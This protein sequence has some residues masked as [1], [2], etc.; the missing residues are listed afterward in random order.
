M[1][2]LRDM[3]SDEFRK[4]AE[5]ASSWIARYL[6]DPDDHPV[7]ARREPG[8]L[9]S[10]LPE[11]PP[12][13]GEPIDEILDDF[14][15]LIV[16]GITHW[17]HPG[18]MAYFGISGSGPGIL[19]ELL[20]AA[21]N[22]NAMLWQTSPA[23]TELEEVALDWLRQMIGLPSA[24][25]GVIMDTASM[26]TFCALAAARERPRDLRIRDLGMAG[27]SALPRLCVYCSDQAHSSVDKAVIALG[28]G[29]QNLRR[30][31]SDDAFR[32][33]VPHLADAIEKDRRAGHRPL[34]VV[35]TVGTTS[36]TSLDPVPEIAAICRNDG[37]W[38]HVD[39]AY[40]G[41]AAVAPEHRDVLEGCDRADSIVIN[42]HKWLFTPIDC[43]AFYF[44][45][46][47]TL[48]DTFSL[49]PEYLRTDAEASVTNFMDYGIQLGRRFRAL[50][51]W[52]VIRY[53]GVDG[54]AR[55]IREHVR[56]AREFAGWIDEDPGFER[57]APAPLS[58]VCFRALPGPPIST[59]GEAPEKD[60]DEAEAA[61]ER[62][63]RE[64]LR[65]VNETGQAY[66]S[67][68]RLKGRYAI[69]L[70]IGN[71]RTTEDH[72]ERA[73]RLLRAEAERLRDRPAP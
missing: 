21:L 63:N 40:A 34:A 57:L 22:V 49:T 16:P 44:R 48:R 70:A 31:P 25:R 14:E 19:G 27:R 23:A 32:L 69:R 15:R 26:S 18:F 55:R 50:K 39:A 62:F 46:P 51:L 5:R 36:T 68:T 11:R 47:E 65:R 58:V 3:P 45:D 4:A 1:R 17:N 7:L 13:R 35:A 64:L 8:A 43:S 24:F 2:D 29:R 61:I 9:R 71:I 56:L 20:S 33:S 60:P 73:W 52:M 66:L 28:L 42:P 67:H 59:S 41:S 10:A 37:I 12:E 38:L 54:L 72:V 6:A 53:F 30:I